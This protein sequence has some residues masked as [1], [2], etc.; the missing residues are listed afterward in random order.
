[1]KNYKYE[2]KSFLEDNKELDSDELTE[3]VLK[4]YVELDNK[5]SKAMTKGNLSEDE[6]SELE[7]RVLKEQQFV[8]HYILGA[9]FGYNIREKNGYFQWYRQAKLIEETEDKCS[10]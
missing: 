7:L 8:L 5:L 10:I 9:Y 6:L 2:I 4:D 1:M 3:K